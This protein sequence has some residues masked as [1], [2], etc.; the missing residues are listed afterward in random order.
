MATSTPVRGP[1]A[2]NTNATNVTG[3]VTTDGSG[4]VQSAVPLPPAHLL[5]P[6]CPPLP[7]K[8]AIEHR[9]ILPCEVRENEMANKRKEC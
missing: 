5:P 9:Q 1:T 4:L 7:A 3:N 8:A 6:L 2:R